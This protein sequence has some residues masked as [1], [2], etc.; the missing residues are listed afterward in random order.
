MAFYRVKTLILFV[1]ATFLVGAT[2]CASTSLSQVTSIRIGMFNS[3]AKARIFFEGLPNEV[4]Q[5]VKR[6]QLWVNAYQTPSGLMEHNLEV[7]ELTTGQSKRLCAYVEQQDMQC[8][9]STKTKLPS[10]SF[11]ST[12]NKKS[13]NAEPL[14]T[15]ANRSPSFIRMLSPLG[16]RLE[17]TKNEKNELEAFQLSNV[18]A[19]HAKQQQHSLQSYRQ[20]FSLKPNSRDSLNARAAKAGYDA[21]RGQF[22]SALRHIGDGVNTG[23]GVDQAKEQVVALGQTLFE[24]AGSAYL[25]GFLDREVRQAEVLSNEAGAGQAFV[26]HVQKNIGQ[27]A[28]TTVEDLVSELLSR[29]QGGQM[30]DSLLKD[31]TD[32]FIL[33]GAQSLIDAGLTAAKRSD[34]Y[35]L[36]NLELEYNLNNFEDSYL[37]ALI[38]QPIYQSADLRHNIFLQG[39]GII[40]EQSVDIDDDESRH[41]LNIGSAYR[42]LTVDEKY[43]IGGNI[44]FDHQ[45]PYDHSR[46]SVGL[47]IK[48]KG[49][50][51]AANYYYPL[52]GYKK[53][54]IANDGNQYEEQA[55]EGYDIE[56]GYTPGRIPKVNLFGKGYQ[57]FRDTE[58]DLLGIEISA[59]YDISKNFTLKG[60]L[61]E[62]NGERD[63]VEFAL[64]YRVPLYDIDKPNLALAAIS[65]TAGNPSMREKIFEKVRRE[66]SIR[67]EERIVDTLAPA[68]IITAQFSALSAGLP[69]DV[70]GTM[71][72]AAVDL[73]F[74]TA[75]TFPNG[76]FGIISFSNGAVANVSAS[77][78]GDVI[79]EFNNTE[80]TVTATNGGFV[81]YISGDGGINTV[82]VP[83]G[84]VNLLGTDIDV[85]DD[86]TT[87]TIQ[88]RAGQVEVVPNIGAA[89]LNGNQ[90]EVVGLTILS[91]A[92]S[93]L[94]DPALTTRRE[95]AYTNLDI[96]NP[97]P[98]TTNK[99]APFINA[100]PALITGPQLVGNNADLQLVFTQA[101]TV[102]GNPFISGLIDANART[103]SYDSAASTSTSLVFRHV[104]VAGDVGAAAITI[105]DLD[106]NGGTIVGTS[107][108]L[109]A[110]TEFTTVVTA[111]T[112]QTAPT[113]MGSSPADNEPAFGS[114]TNIVLNFDENVKANIGNI[115]L[116]DVTDGSDNHIIPIG[117][118]QVT[119]V[120]NTVTIDPTGALDLSTDYDLVI[121]AGV[122]QDT[123]GN[124]FAGIASGELNFTTSN[125][126]TPPLLTGTTPADNTTEVA[127]NANIV[128]TFDDNAVIGSGNITIHRAADNATLE[129]ISVGSANVT[130]GGTTTITIS[131]TSDF[132]AATEL[133]VLVPSTAFE[134]INGNDF[135]GINA[136]TDLSFRTFSP[137]DFAN[138]A[139][140]LDG[141]DLDGDGVPEGA[142]EAGIVAG[143][144]A[145]WVDKSG[146][147]NDTVQTTPGDRPL[148]ANPGANFVG[149]TNSVS[150]G[151]F[152]SIT[153]S[154]A[155]G[156]TVIAVLEGV[157]QNVSGTVNAFLDGAGTDYTFLRVAAADY[158]LSLDGAIG[159]QGKIAID[160]DSFSTTS[161][162]LAAPGPFPTDA[163]LYTEYATM[164]TNHEIL[165]GLSTG[166]GAAPISPSFRSNFI[167]R[168]IIMY[169]DV[170]TSDL[171]GIDEREQ[172]EG[173][174]AHKYGITARLPGAHPFKT[175]AP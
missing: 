36:R 79:L 30:P 21:A 131:P 20:T 9:I 115:T 125:D 111:I 110:L 94:V 83:G 140:W 71:T 37:S 112:D 174:L 171:V 82:N 54:R 116:T 93:L 81:Q 107:N 167:V 87:T 126:I 157:T 150:S 80:L 88:V 173:Y 164:P 34:L 122:I 13:T 32:S 117:D 26:H 156:Q 66:N 92:T 35:A 18:A 102:T 149:T 39:G 55:L 103:F 43:L 53:S 163:L 133:Y 70:G 89:V 146:N 97:D 49:L 104:Y 139:L 38:T 59:E 63:G 29:V 158:K 68:T 40:N 166:G 67:V 159:R 56:L 129:T 51:L 4:I 147:S 41:T 128:L 172:I 33:S 119:I 14:V 144:I 15:S 31:T 1:C 57:Y 5:E 52:T 47:D 16:L 98:P 165:G 50:N 108:G 86:G 65:P 27:Q 60:S 154:G 113:L 142:A 84:T 19:S 96:T 105:N 8:V 160:G 169:S 141:E 95:S 10:S 162:N 151:D 175:T 118:A 77:G 48:S 74:D 85:T 44:F 90:A 17:N 143:D 127:R 62:E 23:N 24:A 153:N 114:A 120:G 137:L 69:F 123:A 3:Q 99:S 106:L 76:D 22:L 12:L 42:Y 25:S 124:D 58:D 7:S 134:D 28:R 45:W 73:P 121:G 109:I 148:F 2:A 61:I 161:G 132:P 168:E 6:D 75:I 145:T 136:V 152:M 101:V 64:K 46:M 155:A 11:A 91:G 135:V 170:K 100:V 72:G 130:G 138:I 78:A